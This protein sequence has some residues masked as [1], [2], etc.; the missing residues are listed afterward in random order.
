MF[1]ELSKVYI[2]ID[3]PLAAMEVYRTGLDKFPNEVSLLL[4]NARVQESIGNTSIANSYYKMAL[5][6]TQAPFHIH[7]NK[8]TLNSIAS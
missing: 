6:V 7:V 4:G 1:L 2:R 5:Q 3:Q 8:L